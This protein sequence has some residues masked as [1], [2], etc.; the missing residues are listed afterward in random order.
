LVFGQ[1]NLAFGQK[2]GNGDIEKNQEFSNRE[3]GI[4]NIGKKSIPPSQPYT[5]G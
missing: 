3:S 2:I 5:V 4:K 1:N